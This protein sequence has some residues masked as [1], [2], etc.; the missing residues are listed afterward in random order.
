MSKN[1]ILDSLG[2]IDDEVIQNVNE[3]RV[4]RKPKLQF[5]R[6]AAFAACFCFD[7]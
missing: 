3:A 2:R 1:Q 7:S 5:R 4:A 6:W